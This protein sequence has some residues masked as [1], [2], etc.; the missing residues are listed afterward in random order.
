MAC[1]DSEGP[2]TTFGPGGPARGSV[3]ITTVDILLME[4]FPVQVALS[5]AVSFLFG[6]GLASQ[7]GFTARAF[8]TPEIDEIE[9]P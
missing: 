4:S 6:L 9:L 8:S 3:F 5:V 2:D 7:F 1:S